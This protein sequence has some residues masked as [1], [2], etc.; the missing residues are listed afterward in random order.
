MPFLQIGNITQVK[1]APGSTPQKPHVVNQKIKLGPSHPEI[2]TWLKT[3][4]P[5]Y[6]ALCTEFLWPVYLIENRWL[7]GRNH[8]GNFVIRQAVISDAAMRYFPTT[9]EATEKSPCRDVYNF[10]YSGN[11]KTVCHVHVKEIHLQNLF[12]FIHF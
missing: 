8:I 11:V 10:N 7:P 9:L 6:H 5:H 2:P 1:L 3:V 4:T 12:N